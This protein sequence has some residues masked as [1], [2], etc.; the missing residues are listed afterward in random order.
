MVGTLIE[1]VGEPPWLMPPI[2]TVAGELRSGAE[3]C[4]AVLTTG[5]TTKSVV[6]ELATEA[7]F[8]HW[9]TGSTARAALGPELHWR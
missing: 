2:I 9:S 3:Q 4:L 1:R 6:C 5:V 7:E 8:T